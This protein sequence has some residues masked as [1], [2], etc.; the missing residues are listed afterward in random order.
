MKNGFTLI[1]LLA[2]LTILAIVSL[3]VIPVTIKIVND[4]RKNTD[5]ISV[6]SYVKAVNAAIMDYNSKSENTKINDTMCTIQSSGNLNCD[7]VIIPVNTKNRHATG[8]TIVIRGQAV[9]SYVDLNMDE[10]DYD[11]IVVFGTMVTPKPTD[12]HKGMVYIDPTGILD[13]CNFEIASENLNERGNTRTLVKNGCMKFYIFDDSGD[14]YKM[15]LDHNTSY[16][17]SNYGT[18]EQMTSRINSQLASDT[19]GWLGNPRLITADEIAHIVGAD[20]ALSW[21]SSK[22]VAFDEEEADPTTQIY[23][24]YLDGSG[25]TYAEWQNLAND[26]AP[27]ANAT[28]KSRYAWLYNY[29]DECKIKGCEIEDSSEYNVGNLHYSHSGYLT[30]TFVLDAEGHTTAFSVANYGA[31]VPWNYDYIRPVI[32]LPKSVIDTLNKTSVDTLEEQLEPYTYVF[33]R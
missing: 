8:G 13:K 5:E 29:T 15:I 25:T 23:G 24:F 16:I 27:I 21:D 30:S 12:T 17:D 1:E 14:T 19:Q 31:L 2:V 6:S 33:G 18:L 3:I 26:G 32:E 22:P 20:T 11:K 9:S 4:T 10:K 7:G 28:N